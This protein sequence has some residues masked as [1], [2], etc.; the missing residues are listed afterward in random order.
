MITSSWQNLVKF[1]HLKTITESISCNVIYFFYSKSSQREIGHSKGTWRTKIEH[2]KGIPRALEGHS[3]TRR[4]LGHS[5]LLGTRALEALYLADS[6]HSVKHRSL[7]EAWQKRKMVDRYDE[8]TVTGKKGWQT[9]VLDRRKFYDIKP[10]VYRYRSLFF[11]SLSSLNI[12]CFLKYFLQRFLSGEMEV[13][14]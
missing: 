4:T 14:N 6:F 13:F 8:F 3:F 5:R 2:S 10:L 1:L 7:R 11:T 12:Q 9:S